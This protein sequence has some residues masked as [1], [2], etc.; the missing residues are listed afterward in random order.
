MV[1]A[2]LVSKTKSQGGMNMAATFLNLGMVFDYNNT[3]YVIVKEEKMI[4]KTHE[5]L[6]R[7]LEADISR[8][9][10]YAQ[11]YLGC[12]D[13]E[14]PENSVT[15]DAT[16]LQRMMEELFAIHPFFATVPA[17]ASAEINAA[18]AGYIKKQ[19]LDNEELQIRLLSLLCTDQYLGVKNVEHWLEM[20]PLMEDHVFGSLFHL[21][22]SI[23]TWIFMTLD[24]TN[25]DLA[26]LSSKSRIGLYG[27]LYSG[28]YMPILKSHMELNILRPQ[29]F[30]GFGAG[31]DF[32]EKATFAVYESISKMQSTPALPA[33]D[34]IQALLTAAEQ[35]T[36]DCER[37]TYVTETLEDLLKLEVYGM[38]REDIRIKRCKNCGRYFILEKG[39]LEY[40]DRIAAGETKPCS[41][42][43]KTRTYEQRI[44]GGNSAMA[45]Y[46][47]AYKTHFARIKSG[48]MTREEFDLWKAEATEKRKLAESS[49]LDFNEYAAW[50]KE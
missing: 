17:N 4:P 32:D 15:G 16:I 49:K 34:C 1:L 26:K 33:P 46:R 11:S 37:R 44:T 30:S 9:E 45:L 39:N 23:S 27:L 5:Y 2:S 47:K 10:T 12:I 24:N 36:E 6:F 19:F 41:E 14:H 21:Q 13:A 29:S 43:G 42:I 50:L 31:L 38:A 18:F 7:F 40:C 8:I 3:D 48:S 22:K 20:A 35:I 25:P 28:E